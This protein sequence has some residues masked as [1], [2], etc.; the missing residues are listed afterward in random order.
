MVAFVAGHLPTYIVDVQ[1]DPK[2]TQYPVKNFSIFAK[3]LKER[4]EPIA[5]N[6]GGANYRIRLVSPNGTL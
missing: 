5:R 3:L 4:C 2:T 1:A 6:A